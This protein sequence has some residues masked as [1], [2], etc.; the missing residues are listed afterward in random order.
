MKKT[1]ILFLSLSIV[2]A[3]FAQSPTNKIMLSKNQQLKF[4]S[5]VKGNV[6]Q[7]MMGQ[8]MEIVMDVNADRNITVK[9][10]A[11]KEYQLDAVTTHI[12]MNMS[13]MGQDMNFDSNNKDDMAGQMK[14]AGK[15]VNVV[16]PLILSTDGKCKLVEK[17]S[18]EKTETNPMNSMMQQI[19][20]GGA[21]EVTT[22]SFFMLIPQGK[23]SGD[24]WTDSVV[25]E[26]SK[27]YWTYTWES[28]TADIAVIKA[29][30]KATINTTMNT[31]G[32]D[33]VMNMTNEIAEDRKVNLTSGV[34]TNKTST[35]KING[36][37]DVMGQTVPMTGTVTT[38]VVAN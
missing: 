33:I 3:S 16:K 25:A 21:D 11:A 36:T 9:E 20:G 13:M 4:A 8:T 15:D 7:E 29:V 19:M 27:T 38:T 12:K 6:S 23:K 10:V 14:E 28:T 1:T 5:S 18:P 31:Q 34:I 30:A 35:A 37:M 32:M 24:N 2:L 26:T 17:A 22:E